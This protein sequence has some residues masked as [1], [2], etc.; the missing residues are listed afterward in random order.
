MRLNNPVGMSEGSRSEA[1]EHATASGAKP[2]DTVPLLLWY[3]LRYLPAALERT[4]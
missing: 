2:V 3:A 1:S 4:C